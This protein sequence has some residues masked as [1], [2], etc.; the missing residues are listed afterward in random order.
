MAAKPCYHLTH[1]PVTPTAQPSP[2]R[3]PGDRVRVTTSESP[4]GWLVNHTPSG[5]TERVEGCVR[6][7][8]RQGEAERVREAD[9]QTDRQTDRV[10][11]DLI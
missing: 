7:K 4:L 2:N 9:R 10:C 8:E 11:V 5:A 6:E 1:E 3:E